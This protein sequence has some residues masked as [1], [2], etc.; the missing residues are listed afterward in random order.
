LKNT[1]GFAKEQALCLGVSVFINPPT[2]TKSKNM[3]KFLA[4]HASQK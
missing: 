1:L 4:K 2:L 3:A